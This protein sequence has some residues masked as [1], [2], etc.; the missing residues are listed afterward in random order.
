MINLND[1]IKPPVE[2]IGIVG[3]F[4]KNL[5]SNWYNSLF[6]ILAVVFLIS[7]NRTFPLI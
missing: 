7:F 6:T 1:N 3:W 4:S 5:F 2:Q